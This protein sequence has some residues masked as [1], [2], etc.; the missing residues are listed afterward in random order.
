VVICRARRDVAG[1]SR[2]LTVG[3]GSEH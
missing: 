1:E 3:G 2:Y